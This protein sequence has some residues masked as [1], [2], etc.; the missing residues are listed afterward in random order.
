MADA[1]GQ[2]LSVPAPVRQAEGLQYVRDSCSPPLNILL[3]NI[4]GVDIQFSVI[5]LCHS[6]I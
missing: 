3:H 5:F 1:S 2:L 6:F 4:L